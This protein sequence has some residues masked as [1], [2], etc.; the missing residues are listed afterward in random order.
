[1]KKLVSIFKQSNVWLLI[2]FVGMAIFGVTDVSLAMAIEGS[3]GAGTH[4]AGGDPL[5]TEI[6]KTESPDLILPDIDERVTKISP[7]K[8]P[9]DQLGRLVA[10]QMKAHGWEFKH[11][12]VDIAPISDVVAAGLTEGTT[13]TSYLQVANAELFNATDTISVVGIKGFEADGTT[14][15]ESDLM[16]YVNGRVVD[17]GTEKVSV[18]PINGKKLVSGKYV[19]PA[20]AQGTEV[21]LLGTAG[22]EGDIRSYN[23]NSLPQPSTGYVQKHDIE[24][25]QTTISQ[26]SLKEVDWSLNDQIEVAT[27]KFREKYETTSLKGIKGKTAVTLANGKTGTAYTSE[28]V[29]WQIKK[30]YELPSE[31]TE[32]DLIKMAKYVFTGQSGSNRKILLMGSDFNLSLSLIDSVQKQTDSKNTEVRW[33]LT[34]RII[35]TNFGEF[36]AMPYDLL[37]RIGMS[38]EAIIIDPDYID[39]WTLRALGSK[40]IDTKSNGEFDGDVNVTTEISAIVLRYLNAHCRVKVVPKVPVTGVTTSAA[41]KALLVGAEYDFGATLTIAPA[42]ATVTDVTYRS[43][44]EDIATVN[45]DG[46][47]TG[48]AAGV[49]VISGT[50]VDGKYTAV[51]TVTVTAA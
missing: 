16:L 45:A 27:T 34:W 13:N 48:I 50:T 12:S 8:V 24:V 10:R 20:I 30:M 3:D 5:N 25:S 4:L 2:L 29:L 18:T 22:L 31:P 46:E 38:N 37:D 1:M 17:S 35:T 7:Y 14:A 6:I 43:S 42:N 41:T 51:C 36:N 40:D 23:N 15:S 19:V 32:K 26:M 39:K 9:I 28:G 21:I 49:A 11:Y 44:D 47:V 33:G